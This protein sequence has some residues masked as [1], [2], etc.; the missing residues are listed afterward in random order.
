[1]RWSWGFN[2]EKR[3]QDWTKPLTKNKI[4]VDIG[5]SRAKVSS[6]INSMVERNILKEK[7]SPN[8]NSKYRCY[9]FNEHYENWKTVT[10]RKRLLG[11][12]KERLLNNNNKELLP[13]GNTNMQFSKSNEHYKNSKTVTKRELLLK[14]N[15]NRS[16]MGTLRCW[17]HPP[18]KG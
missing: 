12:K 9:Q 17:K 7:A 14:G 16:Q 6:A 1:M 10:K 8:G 18:A 13:K 2:N 5:V 3:R 4:A 15:A 11:N